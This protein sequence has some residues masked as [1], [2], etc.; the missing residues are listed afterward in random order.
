M[1]AVV[2]YRL[3]CV[4]IVSGQVMFILNGNLKQSPLNSNFVF[5]LSSE[6]QKYSTLVYQ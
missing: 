2:L 6:M 3:G 5:F 4:A 1:S